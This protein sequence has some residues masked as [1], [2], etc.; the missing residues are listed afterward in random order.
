M[1]KASWVQV[2]PHQHHGDGARHAL[3]QMVL[4]SL[5]PMVQLNN[6]LHPIPN[7]CSRPTLRLNAVWSEQHVVHRFFPTSTMETGHDILFFW[8]ARMVMMSL[9]L[10]GRLPFDTVFLHGLVRLPHLCCMQRCCPG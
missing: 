1:V 2:L 10:T 4:I 8:V 6:M 3:V 9:N 5:N 7:S